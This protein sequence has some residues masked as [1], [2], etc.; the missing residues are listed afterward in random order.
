MNYQIPFGEL[1]NRDSAAFSFLL[2]NF[3]SYNQLKM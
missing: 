1:A 3:S 2:V